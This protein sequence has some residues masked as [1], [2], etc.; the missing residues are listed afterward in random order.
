M[1]SASKRPGTSSGPL[2][3][4]YRATLG[5]AVGTL[6]FLVLVL[7]AAIVLGWFVHL[8]HLPDWGVNLVGVVLALG[9]PFLFWRTMRSLSRHHYRFSLQAALVWTAALAVV[10]SILGQRMHFAA[11]QHRAVRALWE[12]GSRAEYWLSSREDSTWFSWLI[13][14]FGHDPFAKVVEIKVR[15]DAT[16]DT[17]L[18]HHAEFLDLE[19]L[20]FYSGVSDQG[21]QRVAELN[22]FRN[23]RCADFLDTP[24]TDAGME[25][26][27]GWTNLDSLCLNGCSRITDAGLTHLARLPALENLLLVSEGSAKMSLTDAGLAHVGTMHQLKSLRLLGLPITDAGLEYLKQ[28]SNLRLLRLHRTQVTKRG[29]D[30]LQGALPL[31]TIKCP[32]IKPQ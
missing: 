27:A 5:F 25:R 2:P 4:V 29:I 9:V 11:Q 12:H 14:R 1:V 31:C 30:E 8:R 15:N 6:T 24:L 18:D 3:L 13:K 23:L 32:D 21:L 26:L 10:L 7:A 20:G 16:V 28:L 19:S 22:R 17:I